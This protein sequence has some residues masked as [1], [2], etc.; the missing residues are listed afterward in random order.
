MGRYLQAVSIRWYNACAYYAVELARGLGMSGHFSAIAGSMDTPAVA[1]ARSYGI[2]TVDCGR[3]SIKKI[4]DIPALS[5][6]YRKYALENG[7]SLVNV[8]TGSDQ[9]VWT[10]ALRGTGIPILRTSGNQIPPNVNIFSKFML[11]KTKGVIVSCNTIKNYYS[12]GFG[13]INSEIP[14]INGGVDTEYFNY[15]SGRSE[16]RRKNCIPDDAFVFGI[17]GRFSPDKGHNNFFRAAGEISKDYPGVYFIAAGW[18][19]QYSGDD[20]KNMA[21]SAGIGHRT[22]F[23]GKQ[24]DSRDIIS[25]LD[26]GV[27]AS[28][29]SETI[30]RIAMEYMSMGVPVVA[31]DTN[32]IPEVIRD[33]ITGL[34]FPSGEPLKMAECMKTLI[35]SKTLRLSLGENGRN[36][37]IKEYSLKAFAEKTIDAYRRFTDNV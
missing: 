29:R 31:S 2:E 25:M 24:N 30:C 8:H 5:R 23:L 19:A 20:V 27:I 11:K 12:Q 36:T 33:G 26:A 3:L 21:E 13:I 22:I 32:V 6:V 34:I 14:V 28:V 10:I 1:K 4:A 16:L 37:A 7:I 9:T 17:I 15:K 35:G 18:K